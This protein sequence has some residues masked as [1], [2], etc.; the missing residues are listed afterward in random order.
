VVGT[1]HRRT[2]AIGI[3]NLRIV[4][5]AARRATQTNKTKIKNGRAL[6]WRKVKKNI[7]LASRNRNAGGAAHGPR[8]KDAIRYSETRLDR[9]QKEINKQ[10]A[11]CQGSPP[12][13]PTNWAA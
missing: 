3:G 6:N 5:L 4:Q 12:Q 13:K 2:D 1:S 10:V 7:N 8:G 9:P 11:R